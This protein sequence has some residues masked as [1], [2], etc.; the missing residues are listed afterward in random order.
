MGFDTDDDIDEIMEEMERG[1][2]EIESMAAEIDSMIS[3]WEMK[4]TDNQSF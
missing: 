3:E 2:R 1:S 4:Q